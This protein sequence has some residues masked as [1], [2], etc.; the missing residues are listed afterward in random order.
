MG[1]YMN[2]SLNLKKSDKIIAIVGVVILIIA[3]IGIAVYTSSEG[4]KK[5]I[6]PEPEEKIYYVEVDYKSGSLSSIS[7]FTGKNSPYEGT[8]S[9]NKGNLDIITFN[10]SWVDDKAT[11]LGSKGLD[12]LTLEVTDPSGGIHKG[13]DKSATKTK[14]GTV[15][16]TIDTLNV[17]CIDSIEAKD[18]SDAQGQLEQ[19]PYYKDKWKNE[20]FKIKVSVDIG[21]IRILKR[22]FE[23]G[24]DFDLEITYDYYYYELEEPEEDEEFPPTGLENDDY[25]GAIGEFWKNLCN[26]RGFI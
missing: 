23:R 22:L 5:E 20:E 12:T 1:E 4:D 11:F 6:S 17:P 24:N 21:E 18:F 15:V 14:D 19:P 26:G 10:L 2:L 9:I 25:N 3:A 8:I 13:S 7:D 16:I